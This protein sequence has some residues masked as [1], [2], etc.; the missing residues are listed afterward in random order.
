MSKYGDSR[1]SSR[2]ASTVASRQISAASS[3]HPSAERAPPEPIEVDAIVV[4]EEPQ[5]ANT[6][7]A[8]VNAA[9]Y[10]DMNDLIKSKE[11][12]AALHNSIVS[13][14]RALMEGR[15]APPAIQPAD[16][17]RQAQVPDPGLGLGTGRYDA[18]P[19]ERRARYALPVDMPREEPFS[20]YERAARAPR[21]VENLWEAFYMQEDRTINA[22]QAPLEFP[23]TDQLINAG[24]PFLQRYKVIWE[25]PFQRRFKGTEDKKA[26]SPAVDYFL[27]RLNQC[28]RTC[29][30]SRREFRDAIA[31]NCEGAAW[32]AVEPWVRRELGVQ[33]IY[34]R[35]LKQFDYRPDPTAAQAKLQNLDTSKYSNWAEVEEEVRNLAERASLA[36]KCASEANRE[37]LFDHIAISNLVRLMPDHVRVMAEVQS[38]EYTNMTGREMSFCMFTDFTNKFR[39]QLDE[40]LLAKRKGKSKVQQVGSG[41]KNSKKGGNSEQGK[42]NSKKHGDKG[43]PAQQN[44]VS[45]GSGRDGAPNSSGGRNSSDKGET[46]K[47]FRAEAQNGRGYES[48]SK[49]TCPKCRA[50]GHD[51]WGCPYFEGKPTDTICNQCHLEGRHDPADCPFG[52]KRASHAR[53]SNGA[54]GRDGK[55]G[56]KN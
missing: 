49:I 51:S 50:P 32:T 7:V 40:H 38:N 47:G 16:E 15:T 3:R 37:S 36:K 53:K 2:N 46:G 55:G 28:Q 44:Q 22:V 42:D 5:D 33:D 25:K 19:P 29:P 12:Q 24:K 13:G 26:G 1:A 6:P 54:G 14:L 48:Q 18:F 43:K 9:A 41:G 31:A 34:N 27:R 21:A 23:D 20:R 4:A 35:L 17:P 30:L 45:G 52:R 11:G 8:G 39:P 56:S 10:Q